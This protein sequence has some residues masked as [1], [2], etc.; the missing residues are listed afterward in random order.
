ML[1]ANQRALFAYQTYRLY[2]LILESPNTLYGKGFVYSCIRS[3]RD[4]EGVYKRVH[5]SSSPIQ[6]DANGRVAKYMSIYTLLGDYNGEPLENE[7]IVDKNY[8]EEQ[9]YLNNW[10]KRIKAELLEK[11]GFSRRQEE[12][13]LLMAHGKGS[14]KDYAET[15]RIQPKA[16]EKLRSALLAHARNLFPLNKF[17]KASHVIDYLM[18]QKII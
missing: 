1:H 4:K 7:F 2:E 15:M 3:F 5:Q 12:L 13:I 6:Y 14:I 16:V 17:E 18:R 9:L 11:L 8:P 10:Q